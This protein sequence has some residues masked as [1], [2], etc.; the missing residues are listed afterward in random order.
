MMGNVTDYKSLIAFHPGCY[1]E[2]IVDE[3]NITQAEFAERLGI[4]NELV[5]RIINGQAS[6]NGLTAVKLAK[7]TGV[8][9]ETW[10]NLQVRYD[11]K[12]AKIKKMQ[13]D[14]VANSFNV[15]P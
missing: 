9:M 11:A 14:E 2:E 4:S 7:V 10:L 8:S 12:I 6:V 3:L 1:V 5:S 15:K 13:D